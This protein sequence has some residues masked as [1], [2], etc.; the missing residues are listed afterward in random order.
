VGLI[1]GL[2]VGMALADGAADG[3]GEGFVVGVLDGRD[4]C[5]GI[6]V[7]LNVGLSVGRL[8]GDNVG[9][10]LGDKVGENVGLVDGNCF[11]E[12]KM[13]EWFTPK[14]STIAKKL[15]ISLTAGLNV[16]DCDLYSSILSL[17]KI[18]NTSSFSQ[19]SLSGSGRSCLSLRDADTAAASP[20]LRD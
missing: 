10:L 16:G 4:D 15:I 13:R 11:F 5:D 14:S 18:T 17:I 9:R 20:Q 6:S 12:R 2:L 1:L 8:L 7:G 19:L 3:F